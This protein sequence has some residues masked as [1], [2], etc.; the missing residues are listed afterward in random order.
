MDEKKLYTSYD[1]DI[2]KRFSK[3]LKPYRKGLAYVLCSML[4]LG[5][6]DVIMPMMTQ[7]AID[8]F[9]L[10]KT[11]ENFGY[12]IG[13]YL[14]LGFLLV[15]IVYSFIMAAGKIEN[16]IIFEEVRFL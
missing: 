6:I 15:F 9:I 12:F 16:D 13:I 14:S 4:T 11:L 5:I 3:Y 1:L 8:N 2:W 10:K 7:Y